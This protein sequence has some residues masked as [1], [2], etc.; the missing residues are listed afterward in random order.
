METGVKCCKNSGIFG[1][2]SRV[3]KESSK[4]EFSY[5]SMC[6]QNQNIWMSQD[7]SLNRY[8]T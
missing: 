3:K 1:D 5:S 8:G 2:F 7:N 6:Q 4:N